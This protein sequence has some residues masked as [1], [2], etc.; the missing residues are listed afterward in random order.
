[1]KYII[2]ESQ[3]KMIGLL[4]QTDDL[5][6]KMVSSIENSDEIE[7]HCLYIMRKKSYFYDYISHKIIK[8]IYDNNFG[9]S[10]DNPLEWSDVEEKLKSYIQMNYRDM[11][12][13]HFENVCLNKSLF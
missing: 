12:I 2:T 4:K 11:I 6:S 7:M 13:S 1:M 10:S 3:S 9:S 8:N 5:I